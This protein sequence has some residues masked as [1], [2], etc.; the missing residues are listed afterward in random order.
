MNADQQIIQDIKIDKI[1]FDFIDNEVCD[2]L[3]ITATDFFESLSKI[4]SELQES[5]QLL[6]DKRDKLQSQ[7]DEWHIQNKR[8]DPQKYKE[9]LQSIGYVAEKP[10]EF[11][12]EV[13]EVDDEISQVAGPQLVVPITNQRFVLNAVNARWGSLFD[14]LYGTNVIPNKGSM[15]TSFAHNLQRVNRTAELACDFLDE[16]AP[17][18]GASY[19]QI[20]T[21]VKYKGALI[22][23]LND[24]EVATLINPSQYIGLTENGN[25]L[26]KNNNLHI[27]IVCDQERSLHKSGIFDVIL[28][29]A[30]TTIVDFEDSASTVSDE[31]KIH[32]YRNYLGLMKR[33]LSA[34]FVKGGETIT[35][36][37]NNDKTYTD[38][39]GAICKLPGTSLTLV[40]NVGIHMTTEMVTNND[41]SPIPEG[42]LDAM[43]T[44][45]IALHDLKLKMNSKKGSIYIVKPKLHG[46]EEVKFT[47]DLFSAVEK[48]LSIKENTLKIGVMDEERRTTINLKACIFEAR[49]RII[50]INTG[51]LDRTGDEIHTSMMAGAMRCK[52]LIKEEAWFSAYEENNVSSGLECGLYKRAQIGKGMWAQPDQM[53]QMLDNKMV[54]LEAGAS[55]SWVPS[56]TAATLH[57]THYHR[58]NVFRQQQELLSKHQKPNQ[59]DLYK[60]PFLKLA[61]QL[62]EEKIIKE[63]NNNAQ[64]ILGYVVKWI[65]QGIGCS[66]VQDINHIGLMEDRATLRISSQ[67]MA[68]WLHHK[69]CT[70]DQV[71]KAFQEM[72]LIVDE[73]NKNDPNYLALAPNYDSF[74]YKA[75][76]ALAFEGAVQANGYTEDILI[77]FRRKFLEAKKSK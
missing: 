46:P 29:S 59:D 45:L 1:F 33:E 56:P 44:S 39:H 67:H 28:E 11:S 71:N 65:N 63:I 26:L 42:I 74:A 37:L 18:K 10:D 32:A 77:R 38:T 50:F 4:L 5:N 17:L 14:S 31:E 7:I 73:Q 36:S 49:N 24:G 62:S 16:I 76:T 70:K 35:R 48:A 2:G 13:E 27:E 20:T 61:D 8:I 3:E 12:I 52:N 25:I 34:S 69:I 68:N 53:R 23:N 41:G 64:S 22:F 54:H 66:K 60:I 72:A 19:R 30:V 47:M 21:Q 40:R 51:F 43:V 57:A 9:F 55:C 58:F 15:S 6:L 75:S